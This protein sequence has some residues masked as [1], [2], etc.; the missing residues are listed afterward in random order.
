MKDTSNT[1][2]KK[3]NAL[4]QF[5]CNKIFFLFSINN[6]IYKYYMNFNFNVSSK[7]Y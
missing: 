3:C 5:L 6:Q 4:F 1:Y 7:I 2:K